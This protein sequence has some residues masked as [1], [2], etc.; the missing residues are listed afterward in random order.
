MKFS[1]AEQITDHFIKDGWSKSTSFTELSLK[2]AEEKGYH[3]AING[4]NNGRKYFK[5]NVSEN[6]YNDNGKIALY[7]IKCCEQG[8]LIYET[9][10]L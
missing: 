9:K 4:I 7:N 2:E 10:R 3:F 1:T 5:M 6:I 8:E